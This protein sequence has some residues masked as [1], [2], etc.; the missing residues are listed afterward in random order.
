MCILAVSSC[1]TV[2]RETACRSASRGPGTRLA[3]TTDDVRAATVRDVVQ[4]AKYPFAACM[5]GEEGTVVIRFDLLRSGDIENIRVA[6]SSGSVELDDEA[7]RVVT[8]H[9]QRGGKISWDLIGAPKDA[10]RIQIE[11]PVAFRLE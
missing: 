8:A 5:R 7:L 11:L 1:A 4:N 6:R 2:D 10:Q 9:Q 3:T